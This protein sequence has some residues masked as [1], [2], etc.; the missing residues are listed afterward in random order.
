MTVTLPPNPP[1]PPAPPRVKAIAYCASSP[2][3]DP[4]APPSPPLPPIDCAMMP[5]EFSRI[6]QIRPLFST[7]TVLAVAAGCAR[8]TE[9]HLEVDGTAVAAGALACAANTA[10]TAD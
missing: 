3:A 8:S 10:T 1:S 5:C 6:V 4:D 9:R 2:V 7:V